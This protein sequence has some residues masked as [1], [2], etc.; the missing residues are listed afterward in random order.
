MLGGGGMDG[1]YIYILQEINA[2]GRYIGDRCKQW[3][4]MP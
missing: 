3:N 4:I 2:A 1:I